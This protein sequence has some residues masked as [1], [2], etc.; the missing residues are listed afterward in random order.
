M[1]RLFH[2]HIFALIAL[3][4]PD[5]IV[6]G[7][8]VCNCCGVYNN[9]VERVWLPLLSIFAQNVYI[10]FFRLEKNDANGVRQ[11]VTQFS[12]SS[13]CERVNRDFDSSN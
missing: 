6:L 5:R 3:L 12:F 10:L 13:G 9:S 1:N 7:W 8:M 11:E 4:S 2:V